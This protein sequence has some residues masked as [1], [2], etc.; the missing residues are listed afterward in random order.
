M[1]TVIDFIVSGIQTE[2]THKYTIIAYSI[3]GNGYQSFD[4]L[5]SLREY[6]NQR[7]YMGDMFKECNTTTNGFEDFWDKVK[8]LEPNQLIGFR[9]IEHCHH[10][11]GDNFDLKQDWGIKRNF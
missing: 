7:F 8:N 4:D 11:D 2:S 5:Q 9:T 10:D 1:N 3:G 6:F